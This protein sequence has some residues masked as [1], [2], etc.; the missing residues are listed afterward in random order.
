MSTDDFLAE[1]Y[2][3]LINDGISGAEIYSIN[4]KL[5]LKRAKKS[6]I[7]EEGLYD[8]FKKGSHKF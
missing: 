7:K 8:S 5:I 4:N 2:H 3:E 1:N 6:R